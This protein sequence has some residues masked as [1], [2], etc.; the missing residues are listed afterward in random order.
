MDCNRKEGRNKIKIYKISY[1]LLLIIISI[2]YSCKHDYSSLHQ[3]EIDL[4]VIDYNSSEV[5]L[6]VGMS[7]VDEIATLVL[8]RDGMKIGE[9]QTIDQCVIY[10]N[11]LIPNH[12]YTYQC[13]LLENG[14]RASGSNEVEVSTLDTTNHNINWYFYEFGDYS[15]SYLS[16]VWLEGT[17]DIMAVGEILIE[18]NDQDSAGH[19]NDKYS[20]VIWEDGNWKL[21]KIIYQSEH[22]ESI[23]NIYGVW[24]TSLG[25]YLFAAGSIFTWDGFGLA[26]LSYLRDI[27]SDQLAQSIWADLESNIFVTGSSG[28]ISHFDGI[29]WQRIETGFTTNVRDVWGISNQSEEDNIVLAAISDGEDEGDNK[30]IKINYNKSITEIDINNSVGKIVPYTIWFDT[31]FTLFIGGNDVFRKSADGKLIKLNTNCNS[32][33]NHIRGT[34]KNDIFAVSEFGSVL[35]FN[36]NDWKEYLPPIPFIGTAIAVR[37]NIVVA[38][39]YD[40]R[41]GYLFM[42]VRQ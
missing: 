35:H 1:Y 17:Q 13:F 2:F 28:F 19:D 16:D 15:S 33:I 27:Q 31:P 34:A 24:K 10:D 8:L 18:T 20:A 21:E 5:W 38:V 6:N 42:G 25:K 29:E 14:Y 7:M 30:I 37:E 26:E 23:L 3:Q 32:F 41:K 4:R 39:G 12:D 9:V 40:S 11:N 22:Y 36:G